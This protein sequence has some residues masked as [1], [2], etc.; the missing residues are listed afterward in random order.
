MQA[1][2][3]SVVINVGDEPP[4]IHEKNLYAEDLDMPKD[5]LKDLVGDGE[6][7][8]SVSTSLNDKDFGAGFGTMVT[9]T[10]TSDQNSDTLEDAFVIAKGLSSEYAEQAFDEATDLFRKKYLKKKR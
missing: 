8:I 9:V 7:R 6:A 1:G 4:L 3:L 10:L 5:A 2:T